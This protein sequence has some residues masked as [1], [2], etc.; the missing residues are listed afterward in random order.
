[1]SFVSIIATKDFLTIM[2]D[3]RVM[4]INGT[5]IEENYQKFLKVGDSSFIAYAGDRAFCEMLSRDIQGMV[6][7]KSYDTAI[8][9]LEQ[10]FKKADFGERSV[11]M[12][13]GGLNSSGNIE[14]FTISSKNYVIQKQ[15]YYP[16]NDTVSYAFL[17]NTKMGHEEFQEKLIELLRET[18]YGAPSQTIQAQRLLNN[19]I[20]E[21][22]NSVN[23]STFR[24]VIK[25]KE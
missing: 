8:Q 11:L 9:V 1:M 7:S 10:I 14:F 15:K 3:G 25:V 17:N 23:K 6:E 2:S 19:F 24:F 16:E 21:L 20:A 18:G 13:I 5:P 12:G 4:G 22:D